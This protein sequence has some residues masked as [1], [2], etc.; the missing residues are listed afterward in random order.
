MDALL[1][2]TQAAASHDRD[3]DRVGGV[4]R[5]APPGETTHRAGPICGPG[6]WPHSAGQKLVQRL[7]S[8][9]SQCEYSLG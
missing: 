1:S 3:G 2:A 6:G 8:Y 7:K 9:A 4:S 5:G